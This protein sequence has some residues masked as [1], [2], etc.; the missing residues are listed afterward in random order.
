MCSIEK[1]LE[2]DNDV[3]LDGKRKNIKQNVFASLCVCLCFF[4][5][6]VCSLFVCLL[7]GSTSS[8]VPPPPSS[9]SSSP[10]LADEHLQEPIVLI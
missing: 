10:S 3:R 6:G 8:S 5:L 1:M 9:T 7:P 2:N 4:S